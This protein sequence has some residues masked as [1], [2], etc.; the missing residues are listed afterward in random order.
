ML[1]YC[2]KCT[3][4]TDSK[5][6]KFLKTTNG[7]VILL[8]NCALYN[9]KISRFIKEQVASEFCK[10]PGIRTPLSKITLLGDILF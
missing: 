7:R 6:S 10:Q 8:S 3:K 9:S 5:N 1:S 2:L 4:D